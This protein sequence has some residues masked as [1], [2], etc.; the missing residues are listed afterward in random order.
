MFETIV[1]DFDRT[2]DSV[3]EYLDCESL[4]IM[5]SLTDSSVFFHKFINTFVEEITEF[6]TLGNLLQIFKT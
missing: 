3:S 1:F 4:R 6:H 5:C 2:P